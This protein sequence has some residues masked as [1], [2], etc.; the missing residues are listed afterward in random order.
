MGALDR[1]GWSVLYQDGKDILAAI[2]TNSRK[3]VTF[4]QLKKFAVRRYLL[5]L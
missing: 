4:Q 1:M 2:E 5:C 3:K